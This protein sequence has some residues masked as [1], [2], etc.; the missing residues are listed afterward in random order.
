[1]LESLSTWVLV[2][3]L[4]LLVTY[5]ISTWT[6]DN[7]SKRNTPSLKPIPLLGNMAP[8]VFQRMSFHDFA[9]Y[10]YS[11]SKGY[12]NGGVYHF[13]ISVVLLRNP[14]LIKK[15]DSERF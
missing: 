13:M 4:T 15:G 3:G 14:E 8:V 5:L 12:K 11:K 10:M 9:V 6:H 7:F 2:S 1:M